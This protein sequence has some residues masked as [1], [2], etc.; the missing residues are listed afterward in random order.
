MWLLVIKNKQ[1]VT[2]GVKVAAQGG[3]KPSDM[4]VFPNY[5]MQSQCAGS[6][7]RDILLFHFVFILCLCFDRR[8]C[9]YIR[10]VSFHVRA[11]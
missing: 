7:A 8:T 6:Y 10:T 1:F 11:V 9:V 5:C 2:F 3:C 4:R